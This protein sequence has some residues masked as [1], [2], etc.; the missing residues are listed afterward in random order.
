[1]LAPV[2]HLDFTMSSRFT[3]MIPALNCSMAHLLCSGAPLFVGLSKTTCTERTKPAP[4]AGMEPSFCKS[5]ILS[6]S[7]SPE[8]VEQILDDRRCL[9]VVF[10]P[11]SVGQ[12]EDGVRSDIPIGAVQVQAGSMTG[13]R[14]PLWVG[15]YPTRAIAT[16]I[17]NEVSCRI[18]FHLRGNHLGRLHLLMP[19]VCFPPA[20]TVRALSPR[21]RGRHDAG[22]GT[23]F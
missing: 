20:A 2:A 19:M 4:T 16:W 10:I 3:S 15:K 8:S 6:P 12:T 11:Q 17:T 14:R 18:V 22:N 1:M 13:I 21:T 5:V 9:I 23:L 7:V